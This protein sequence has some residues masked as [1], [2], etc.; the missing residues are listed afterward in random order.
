MNDHIIVCVVADHNVPCLDQGKTYQEDRA[1]VNIRNQ[2]SL[3]FRVFI[4]HN[5]NAWLHRISVVPTF[6]S[7]YQ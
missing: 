6:L 4:F 2:W 3:G 5:Y 7:N 1:I